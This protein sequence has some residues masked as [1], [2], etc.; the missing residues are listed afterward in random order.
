MP[1]TAVNKRKKIVV[2]ATVILCMEL[3]FSTPGSRP[4]KTNH[5][6]YGSTFMVTW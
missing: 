1:Y 3:H 6:F 2:A 4:R 5:E